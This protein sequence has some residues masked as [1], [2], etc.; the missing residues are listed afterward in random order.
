MAAR[1][2]EDLLPLRS[3]LQL[4]PGHA[5]S[6]EDLASPAD[7]VLL[8]L[9]HD[10]RPV[11]ELRRTAAESLPRI[12]EHGKRALIRVNNPRTGLLRDDLEA[13]VGPALDA[14]LLNAA[15]DPQE[16]RDAA[17]H[18][19]ELELRRGLE[20]G[21]VLLFAVV[22]GARGLIR[23]PEFMTAVARAAGLVF[24]AAGYAWDVGAREEELGPRLAYARGAIVAAARAYGGL[25]LIVA[26]P[27]QLRFHAQS[28]FAGAIVAD[29]RAMMVANEVFQPNQFLRRRLEEALARYDAARSEG[30]TVARYGERVIDG[31]AARRLRQRLISR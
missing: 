30:G 24:D 21:H 14:V 31:A 7:A 11:S 2:V 13:V 5:P 1:S 19:R 22:D 8:S 23:A 28:G 18:L 15:S 9:A 16:L 25:P 4:P 3:I 10:A 29:R 26:S 17:V 12:R 20:P 6:E 27:F